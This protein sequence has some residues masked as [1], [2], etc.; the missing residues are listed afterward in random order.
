MPRP[1][2]DRST[3]RRHSA[4]TWRRGG[5]LPD[6]PCG[7]ELSVTRAEH[8]SAH[9]LREGVDSLCDGHCAQPTGSGA[10][11]LLDS[12]PISGHS[13]AP[14]SFGQGCA[15]RFRSSPAWAGPQGETRWPRKCPDGWWRSAPPPSQPYT[16]QVWYQ[17]NPRPTASLWPQPARTPR[18]WPPAHRSSSPLSQR[19]RRLW[20]LQ[21]ACR[22]RP[23]PHRRPRRR[24]QPRP[25]QITSVTTKYP[26][27]RIASLPGQVVQNQ[28]ANVNLVT[29]ATS[30]SQAFKQAVQQAL[31]Q[32][33]ALAASSTAAAG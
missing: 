8:A 2:L 24:R 21:P 6:V 9:A 28:T 18:G 7:L 13:K 26:A 12:E 32:A 31:A 14:H 5:G 33:Q 3:Q 10:E 16:S 23:P 11:S 27:S 1:V 19:P 4:H 30:S 22:R 20:S 25:P 17:P 15:D 29:G